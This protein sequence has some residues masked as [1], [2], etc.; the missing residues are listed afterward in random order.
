MFPLVDT[1]GIRRMPIFSSAANNARRWSPD[2]Y[3][4][5][6]NLLVEK[7]LPD[8]IAGIPWHPPVPAAEIE[9][10]RLSTPEKVALFREQVRGRADVVPIRWESKVS[11]GA[12]HAPACANGWRAGVGEQ[13]RIQRSDCGHPLFIPL[14]DSIIYDPLAGKK[15]AGVYAL[16]G[17]DTDLNELY[18]SGGAV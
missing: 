1:I 17:N 4:W 13:P 9:P 2:A 14:S 18:A 7:C 15:T 11:S 5:P 10:S 3:A 6:Q 8:C 16:L 12:G